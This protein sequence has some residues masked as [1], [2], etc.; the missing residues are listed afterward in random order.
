MKRLPPG[1]GTDLQRARARPDDALV[2]E[3]HGQ[4]VTLDPAAFGE[5]ASLA[6]SPED[7]ARALNKQ[8]RRRL[9]GTD[10]DR[11]RDDLT[12]L[13]ERWLPDRP[14]CEMI[15][16]WMRAGY[17]EQARGNDAGASDH[18]LRTWASVA[19]ITR[20]RGYATIEEFDDAS[21][22]PSTSTT[23]FL[24]C[25]T[26]CTTPASGSRTFGKKPSEWPRK[27]SSPFL[28]ETLHGSRLRDLLLRYG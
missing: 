20:E 14:T 25:K 9:R 17:E 10:L 19:S 3:L 21:A 24:T 2:D 18:W 23:A 12:A 8:L 26:R 13:W 11:L 16:D 28:V 6:G 7:L 4:G 15:D 27:E 22:E 1:P 5:A